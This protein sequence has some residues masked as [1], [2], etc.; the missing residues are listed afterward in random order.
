M[1]ETFHSS[2][3]LQSQDSCRLKFGSSQFLSLE[4][5]QEASILKMNDQQDPSL[6]GTSLEQARSKHHQQR[7]DT[8]SHGEFT[9]EA[10]YLQ[11]H[12][13]PGIEEQS[14]SLLD[15]SETTIDHSSSGYLESETDPRHST[16][17]TPAQ[18]T[19]LTDTTISADSNWPQIGGEDEVF[20]EFVNY[21]A[22]FEPARTE[23]MPK[24]NMHTTIANNP[25]GNMTDYAFGYPLQPQSYQ[26]QE[27]E[28]EFEEEVSE[29]PGRT[30]AE[31]AT[32]TRYAE[33]EQEEDT[34]IGP[35]RY[36]CGEPGCTKYRS[37]EGSNRLNSIRKHYRDFHPLLVFDEGKLVASRSKKKCK[38]MSPR[39]RPTDPLHQ[40][41]PLWPDFLPPY[42]G[43]LG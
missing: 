9:L 22:Y 15:I 36:Y 8:E 25:Q 32:M 4:H 16:Q 30:D 1:V 27:D 28:E 3:S 33:D 17:Q 13:A 2:F 11:C 24:L 38:R 34:T 37:A 21:D 40:Q 14:S 6:L 20:S 43:M 35:L 31:L 19:P 41:A 18:T 42:S 7:T 29:H 5:H 10:Q 12:R 23:Q 26:M 39:T